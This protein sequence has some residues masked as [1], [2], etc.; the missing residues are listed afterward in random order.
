MTETYIVFPS[1]TMTASEENC[2]PASL[3][4][5]LAVLL[6]LICLTAIL[7]N[8]IVIVTLLRSWQNTVSKTANFLVLLLAI[9]DLINAIFV[10][11]LSFVTIVS[12]TWL[13][14]RIMCKISGFIFTLTT[15]TTNNLLSMI[16]LNRFYCIDRPNVH[17]QLVR[18]RTRRMTFYSLTLGIITAVSVAIPWGNIDF[19]HGIDIMCLPH[20]TRDAKGLTNFLFVWTLSFIIPIVLMIVTY[21]RVARIVQQRARRITPGPGD[22]NKVYTITGRYTISFRKD[23]VIPLPVISA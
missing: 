22:L 4:F 20:F 18:K 23:S 14:G 8:T 11:P 17:E 21:I 1:V 2:I 15:T 7:G 16:S 12:R 13:L 3:S 19:T 6:G 5:M 10:M 9:L